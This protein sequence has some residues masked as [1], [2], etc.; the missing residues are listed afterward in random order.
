MPIAELGYRHWEGART[1]ALRRC[2]AIARSEVAIAY[3]SSKLL[4]RF[5][6]F[7]WTPILYFCPFFLAIGYIADPANALD[8]GAMLT[9]MAMEFLSREA[10]ERVRENPELFLPEI[11]S[12]A[13]YFFFAYTQSIFAMLVVAIVGPPLIARDM[14]SKAFLVYFSKPI[15]PWQYLA[16]KL[17]T[18]VFFVA[19]MTLFP[20]LLLYAVGIALSPTGG[21]LTATLPILFQIVLSSVVIAIPV[22]MLVLLLSS[23]TKD[24]RIATFTWV[25]VWIFGEIAFRVLTIGGSTGHHTPPAWASLL[26]I[27]ELTTKAT[28]GI[29]DLRGSIQSL[30]ENL[31]DSAGGLD[32]VLRGMA[33]E[34]GDASLMERRM[35]QTDVLDIGSA[36]YPP[37]VSLAVLAV[38]S[39]LC[40][41]VVLR[42]VTG[43]VRI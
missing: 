37:G 16:G 24:R 9:E 20:A 8:G 5:L 43:P 38:I 18:I 33:A 3:K 26:S 36:G 4:R 41:F 32:R 35:S 13:F 14:K 40:A 19:S 11:W 15:Q 27:R 22:G 12:I 2:V 7:A 10:I 39:A 21:T 17:A 29:F 28:A 42:R 30:F 25:A 6:V 1:S 23:L 31:G 34:M